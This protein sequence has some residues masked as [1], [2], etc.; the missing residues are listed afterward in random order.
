MALAKEMP[1]PLLGHF[2]GFAQMS[3]VR[4]PCLLAHPAAVQAP[5][6]SMGGAGA[7]PKAAAAASG[8]LSLSFPHGEEASSWPCLQSQPQVWETESA[9]GPPTAEQE[10]QKPELGC[11]RR[12]LLDSLPGC[13][14]GI[15][16]T[17]RAPGTRGCPCQ[18]PGA[19]PEQPS[20]ERMATCDCCPFGASRSMHWGNPTP[21]LIWGQRV[22]ALWVPE[23][24]QGCQ[25]V[26]PWPTGQWARGEQ[27]AGMCW[28]F[29]VCPFPC[30]SLPWAGPNRVPRSC[31]P[32][33]VACHHRT[34]LRGLWQMSWPK[35]PG[36][37]FD[38]LWWV[39]WGPG[40]LKLKGHFTMVCVCCRRRG[41]LDHNYPHRRAGGG[42][43]AQ[44][45]SAGGVTL[46]FLM[47]QKW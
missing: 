5:E 38:R 30:A 24:A 2:Q 43:Q 34:S 19:P 22:P 6:P 4:L 45:A 44:L 3:L 42:Q 20:W 33:P 25:A 39:A 32:G 28:L 10:L 27:P 23:P 37:R 18:A 46:N 14:P 8:T 36:P 11:F 7:A 47:Q 17:I 41:P 31:G 12:G 1:W 9:W 15:A 16:V 40:Q 29:P 21:L 13:N 26:G 35:L